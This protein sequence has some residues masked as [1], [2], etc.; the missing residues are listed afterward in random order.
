MKVLVD[1]CIWSLALR[2]KN[3]QQNIY[4]D[5]LKELIKE[6]RVQIKRYIIRND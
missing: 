1:T 4:I 3:I 5:E 2:R 6:V